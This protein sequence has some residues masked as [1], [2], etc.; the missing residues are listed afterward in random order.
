MGFKKADSIKLPDDW[1]SSVWRYLSTSQ[2]L[3]ILEKDK[4]RFTRTDEFPD[5]YEGTLPEKVLEEIDFHSLESGLPNKVLK[6]EEADFIFRGGYNSIETFQ[7]TFFHNCWNFKSYESKPMWDSKSKDG[8]GVAIKT[9]VE[10]L[11]GCFEVFDKDY[12][13][14][15]LVEY[16]DYNNFYQKFRDIIDTED[17][18]S[19]HFH[20]PI[21]FEEENEL[22]AMVSLLPTPEATPFDDSSKYNVGEEVSL[23]WS[24]QPSGVDIPINKNRLIQEVRLSPYADDWQKQIIKDTLE[25]HEVDAPVSK[26]EIFDK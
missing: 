4:L 25:T 13:F 23:D 18:K 16:G 2:L 17:W 24:K 14:V 22:R 26:S 20:K 10:D 11:I 6:D 9:T 5:P 21:E 1:S 15:G 7:N 3:S 19:V 8:E 12:V